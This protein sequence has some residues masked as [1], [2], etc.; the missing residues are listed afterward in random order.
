MRDRSHLLFPC[1]G[2]LVPS[3]ITADPMS[4]GPSQEADISPLSRFSALLVS[5]AVLAGAAL[6]PSAAASPVVADPATTVPAVDDGGADLALDRVEVQRVRD[7]VNRIMQDQS[8]ELPGHGGTSIESTVVNPDVVRFGG[9]N[10]YIVASR[11]A[12]HYWGK[13]F[14]NEEFGEID[15]AKVVF[16]AS[17]T[18]FSDALSGGAAAAAYGGP[19][20]LT[21]KDE[22]PTITR[23]SLDLLNPD[24]IVVL[25]GTA[26]VSA[27]VEKELQRYVLTPDNVTRVD[28]RNRYAVSA[29]LASGI[30]WSDVAY[31]ASGEK[32]PDGLAGGATAGW[33]IS[34][35][36]LT[37]PTVVPADVVDVLKTEVLPQRIYV[38][39]GTATVSEAVVEQ[40][41]KEVTTDVRRI[42][43]ANRYE[44]AERLAD[45]HLTQGTATVAS[46]ANWPDALAGSAL[47]GV[48]GSKLLL[49][50]PTTLPAETRRAILRHG[51]AVID[52]LGGPASVSDGVLGQLRALQVTVP[53]AQ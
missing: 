26:T 43:G 45:R 7:R 22:L 39:G 35:L 24:V 14:W 48:T 44:V 18:G 1:A 2:L 12:E 13:Y 25:G 9:K 40:L 31:V 15:F 51:L 6:A 16:V 21:K 37:K 11:L 36:L 32:F 33:E 29:N 10:R 4:P 46:G 49:V 53:D 19:M 30:G 47:A 41:K 38:L 3:L 23:R 27:A 5:L 17:G 50:K 28:G 52:V 42:D 20:L 34:P 8:V